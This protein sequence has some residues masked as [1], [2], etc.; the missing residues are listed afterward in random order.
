MQNGTNCI[1][2]QLLSTIDN[3]DIG[4]NSITEMKIIEED[5]KFEYNDLFEYQS[6]I[7]DLNNFNELIIEKK[8]KENKYTYIVKEILYKN[9]VKYELKY[10]LTQKKNNSTLVWEL[11]RPIPNIN[12]VSSL[13]NKISLNKLVEESNNISISNNLERNQLIRKEI[14]FIFKKLL[15]HKARTIGLLFNDRSLL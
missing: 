2:L 1:I 7:Y 5:D 15:A 12:E 8:N 11:D 9:Q 6:K 10:T 3:E 13:E 14:I 4:E